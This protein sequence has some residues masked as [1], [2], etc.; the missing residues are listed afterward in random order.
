M[1]YL[2]TLS[3]K[4]ETWARKYGIVAKNLAKISLK[5]LIPGAGECLAEGIDCVFEIVEHQDV[6][7]LET[8]ENSIGTLL[9][10]IS[11]EFHQSLSQMPN[12]HISPRLTKIFP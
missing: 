1:Q 2:Q 9:S 5:T 4:A 6:Q 3:A 11:K 10:E 12:A 8:I 7:L